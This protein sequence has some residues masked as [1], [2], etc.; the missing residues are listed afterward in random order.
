MS[1]PVRN[2]L[3]FYDRVANSWWDE[4]APIFTLS[5]LNPGRFAYFDRFVDAWQGRR[6]LDV[7]CGGGYTCEFLA[8]RGAQVTGLDLSTPCLAMANHHAAQ[9]K[10][11]IDYRQGVGE[12]LPFADGSFDVVICVDVL[13]H[14]ADVKQTCQEIFRVLR[15]AG[16]FAF[17]T[18]NR[19]VWSKLV[20]IH[21]LENWLKLI[22]VGVHDWEKFIPPGEL[23]ALL[24]LIGFSPIQ[25]AGFNVF[26]R[27]PF[28]FMRAFQLWQR[29]QALNV[30][31]DQNV[32]LM[33]IGFARKPLRS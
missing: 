14:V 31:I 10:L 3:E 26:G 15:P 7:G 25:Y 19:T 2:D 9:Q 21:L 20:M 24:Q 16:L 4:Q 17:D 18:I 8:H 1:N 12:A 6:V 28:D 32:S 29:T 5:R 22:P 23:K 33:Y 13:E 30:T 11:S 27:S